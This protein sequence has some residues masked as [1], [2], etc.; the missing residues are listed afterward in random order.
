MSAPA[1]RAVFLDR[2]GVLNETFVRDGV[3][4][5]PATPAETRI[6]SGVSQAIAAL[7][8]LGFLLI[9]VTNQPDVARGTQTAAGVEAINQVLAGALPLDEF[10][11][12]AHDNRDNC[13]CRK[14]EPGMLLAA[15]ET[16]NIDLRRS[17]MIGDRASDVLAGA[18]AGCRTILIERSYSRVDTCRPDFKAADLLAASGIIA[19]LVDSESASR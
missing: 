18:A 7:K 15:A 9:V 19:A 13:S 3:A 14:P 11:V 6:L 16:H 5:P 4:Y 1:S 2:D 8:K 17:F 12:C 10:R